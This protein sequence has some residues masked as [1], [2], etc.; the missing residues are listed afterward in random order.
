M[1]EST[2]HANTPSWRT[3]GH[4]FAAAALL[5]ILVYLPGTWGGWMLDDW[6]SLLQNPA[7]Q[8]TQL[9]W[10]DL[11]A[12]ASSG[13][14]GPTGRPLSMVSFALN[15][16]AS[17]LDPAAYKLTNLA[18]H[19]LTAFLLW[20]LGTLLLAARAPGR[21]SPAFT[22]SD[23]APVVAAALWL[24]HPLMLSTVLYVV[25]RMTILAA[26]FTAAGLCAYLYGRRALAGDKPLRGGLWIA[27][28]LSLGT[29]LATL[30]KENGVLLPVYAA[31]MELTLFK[32]HPLPDR[33]RRRIL[34][35]L[36]G[37]PL[38]V[39]ALAAVILLLWQP[40]FYTGGYAGRAFT[41]SDRLWTETRVLWGYLRD[42]LLPDPRHMGLYHDDI[43]PS[44]GPLDP[45]LTLAAAAG[46]VALAA[47]G[48]AWRRRLPLLAFAIGFFFVSHSIESTVFGLELAFDHRQYLAAWAV[49]FAV[50]YYL[51]SI[52]YTTPQVKGI[53]VAVVLAVFAGLTFIRAQAWRQPEIHALYE[54]ANHPASARAHYA[55][56]R[57]LYRAYQRGG[58]RSPE[59]AR[60]A[61]EHLVR[62]A[63]LSPQGTSALFALIAMDVE[64][65]HAADETTLA[66]L[67]RR[68][69]AGAPDRATPSW[70][71]YFIRARLQGRPS[72][73]SEVLG[74]L[75]DAASHYP[76]RMRLIRANIAATTSLYHAKIT[77][78]R[79]AALASAREAVTLA[80]KVDVYRRHLA[81]LAAEFQKGPPATGATPPASPA[82][83]PAEP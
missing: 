63:T 57:S 39:L 20:R 52:R 25:Q 7:V 41:L 19:V 4:A 32:D 54:V 61:R 75:L 45:P 65:G 71:A 68:L 36:L 70:L 5:A 27:S 35:T 37:I 47:A 56:G 13:S 8:I 60:L 55:A 34:W 22:A 28:G 23:W 53:L 46:L 76:A 2:L 78:D 51:F 1:T 66:R 82:D 31:V 72:L 24:L 62:A 6:G 83:G 14:A 64:G 67:E 48:L 29:L 42:T 9:R 74:R 80:P 30:A 77:G 38:A 11:A 16:A 50:S 44:R 3:P 33:R 26:L 73:P 58:R 49:L 69:R 79:A 15:H 18:L 10:H 17:G 40:G 43:V 12:A 81:R 21:P 59:L